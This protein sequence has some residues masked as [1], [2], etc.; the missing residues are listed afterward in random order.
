MMR[1]VIA[2]VV[3]ALVFCVLDALWLGVLAKNFYREQI[4]PLLLT[5]PNRLAAALFY[6][7]YIAGVI[8][9]A[10]APALAGS[11]NGAATQALLRGAL[12]GL[13]AY[14]TYDLT[15]M[16]TLRGWSWTIAAVDMA[17][18]MVVTGVAAC[19]GAAVTQRCVG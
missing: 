14:M 9:F 17:W 1:Y 15:N 6:V 10:V 2:Y 19:A 5:Q 8:V 4:G 18:G 3:V 16:A 7:S 12:F 13:L 11:P